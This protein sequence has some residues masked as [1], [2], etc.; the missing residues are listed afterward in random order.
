MGIQQ[1]T[2]RERWEQLWLSYAAP[3]SFLVISFVK[4]SHNY[5][6]PMHC[7]PTMD[8]VHVEANN[9]DLYLLLVGRQRGSRQESNKTEDSR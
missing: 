5:T 6:F 7:I 4:R 1:V 9:V 2:W 3:R 8:I